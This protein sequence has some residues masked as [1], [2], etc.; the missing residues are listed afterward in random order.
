M[1]PQPTY[2]T[3]ATSSAPWTVP[4]SPPWPCSTGSATSTASG[5]AGP[6]AGSST[7]PNP[8]TSATPEVAGAP[9]HAGSHGSVPSGQSRQHPSRVMPTST[10]SKR[11]SRAAITF[12]AE[13]HEMSCSVEVPPNM[14]ATRVMARP[15]VRVLGCTIIMTRA[16]RAARFSAEALLACGPSR[17]P[18]GCVRRCDFDFRVRK[19]LSWG[20]VIA[21]Y[22]IYFA[23]AHIP[24]EGAA[25]RAAA[26]RRG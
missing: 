3:P 12:F 14:R 16:T 20:N 7:R 19:P 6:S 23:T 17:P 1:T 25:R 8:G 24:V 2:G 22:L 4:S 10:R 5:R 26:A 13:R 11:P 18:N 15:F 21:R 9:S